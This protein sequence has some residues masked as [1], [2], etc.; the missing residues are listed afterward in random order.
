MNQ[1]RTMILKMLKDGKISLEEAEAL[2]EVLE[3]SEQTKAG[4]DSPSVPAE[5]GNRGRGEHGHAARER[6]GQERSGREHHN[7]EHGSREHGGGSDGEPG[8]REGFKFDF[9]FSSF[10]RSLRDSLGGLRDNIEQAVKNIGNFDFAAEIDRAI[11]SARAA[12]E[13]EIHV[14]AVDSSGAPCTEFRLENRWGDVE[15]D[16]DDGTDVR[17]AA[18]PAVWAHDDEE[19][20]RRLADVDLV[21][22]CENGTISVFDDSPNVQA[23]RRLRIDYRIYVPRG[24]KISVQTMSGDVRLRNVENGVAVSTMSGDIAAEA[25]RGEQ[26]LT[27]KSGDIELKSSEGT[28]RCNTLGGNIE[29]SRIRSGELLARA[30]SGDVQVEVEPEVGANIV[31]ETTSGD[32][33]ARIPET[34]CCSVRAETRSGDIAVSIPVAVRERGRTTLVGT[35]GAG[36]SEDPGTG[37]LLARTV[38]GDIELRSL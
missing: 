25:I 30:I 7:R 32:I 13:R 1:E 11:G 3:T 29:C 34:F 38:S 28:V 23:H 6:A 16:G 20:Q 5:T 36:A 26:Q 21:A 31:L 37:S 14:D 4:D 27:T 9:D 35:L 10:G 8:S 2:M 12:D 18:R 19:A 17:I 24:M 33:S 15:I 22:R